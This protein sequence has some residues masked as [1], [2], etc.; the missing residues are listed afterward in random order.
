MSP[1]AYRAALDEALREYERLTAERGTLDARIGQLQQTIGMLTRLCGLSPTVPMG[2]TDACR[3]VL[4]G[5][6]S[7]MTAI[8]VRE[9]LEAIGIFDPSKYAN[10]LAVIHTTLKR[11]EESGEAWATEFD[12]SN[13]TG[14][15]LMPSQTRGPVSPLAIV[16]KDPDAVKTTARR[17]GKGGQK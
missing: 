1:D 3:L 4:R 9:R 14:Y 5:A 7:P 11:F 6:R 13:K 17:T 12:E 15:Q 16:V 2:L 8:Q 10:P